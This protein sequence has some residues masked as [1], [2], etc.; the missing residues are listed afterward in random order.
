MASCFITVIYITKNKTAVTFDSLLSD[1]GLDAER[2]QLL[3]ALPEKKNAALSQAQGDYV[4]FIYE[5]DRF[6]DRAL[7]AAC[8]FMTAHE[9]VDVLAMKIKEQ[10]GQPHIVDYIFNKGERVIDLTAR[11]EL[12][13]VQ[14]ALASA[15]LRRSVLAKL[16]FDETLPYGAD[17]LFVNSVLLQRLCLGVTDQA[18]YYSMADSHRVPPQQLADKAYYL[19]EPERFHRAL[20]QLSEQLYG[21]VVP[22]VQSCLGFDLLWRF[23]GEPSLQVLSEREQSD[24]AATVRALLLK[25]DDTV[26]FRHPRHTAIR[27]KQLVARAKYGEELFAN[28][29]LKDGQLQYKGVNLLALRKENTSL[30]ILVRAAIDDGRLVLELLLASWLRQCADEVV[31]AAGETVLRPKQLRYG[32]SKT[33]LADGE[34]DYYVLLHYEAKL[35]ELL[36]KKGTNLSLKPYLV[37]D[38]RRE[39]FY[40]NHGKFVVSARQF[41]KAYLQRGDFALRCV[42]DAV[43]VYRPRWPFLSQQRRDS[44][45]KALLQ[46]LG[47]DDVAALRYERLPAFLKKN[48]RKGRIWLI[49]DRID[50]AGDNGEVLFKYICE[51]RPKGVRPVFVIGEKAEEKVKQRLRS[52]GETVLFEDEDYPLYFLACEKIISSSAGEHTINPF[53]KDK[54]YYADLFRFRYYFMN[55]G[56]NCGDCSKWLN[57]YNK[58]IHIFFTTGVSERKNILD[59][60]YNLAPEQVVLTGMARFDALYEDTKKQLLILPSWRRAYKNCYDDKTSSVYYDGFKETEYYQF[61]NG[62]MQDERLLAVM[63]RHGYTGLFCLHPIFREQA[64]DFEENDVF[65]VNSGFVDYNKVFAESSVMVTDYSTIAFDFA[66]LSK[67][68]VYTQFDKEDFYQHQIY[69]EC[70]DYAAEGFGPVCETLDS[71]VEALTKLI[72]NDCRNPYID[73]VEHFFVHH[74]KNNAKRILEAVLK[75][76]KETR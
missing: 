57:E 23:D 22:F 49:S 58:N 70:F 54:C 46:E 42:E 37:K 20:F 6:G 72:E 13:C 67:P 74:D 26:L 45:A 38:D 7:S 55:H 47:R 65:Q 18:V 71:A 56:V 50:N 15:V 1:Q 14:T 2:V 48:K 75:D 52:I 5:G 29:A 64:R 43:R 63:R 3:T 40:I 35:R 17:M 60:P 11:N 51:H 8:A 19:T 73:R 36:P 76:D 61:Y 32:V 28:T 9:D 10:T 27:T 66:Y 34:Q 59:R 33:V 4:T 30:A 12:F 53:G 69:D 41:E 21:E 16:S 31:F 25:I 62:L 24:Y 44:E 68:I 39:T